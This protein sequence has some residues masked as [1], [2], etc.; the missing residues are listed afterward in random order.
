MIAARGPMLLCL[1]AAP[2]LPAI[3]PTYPISVL[4][5]P[6]R[7]DDAR[8]LLTQIL[9]KGGVRWTQHALRELN[10]DGITQARARI[11]LRAGVVAEAEWEHGEWRHQVHAGRDVLVL[12]FE[13]ESSTVVITGWR[14]TR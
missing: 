1:P 8:R 12:T 5:Q 2:R 14:R 11:V 6:L 9:A 3:K 13:D 7:K 4:P 10:K